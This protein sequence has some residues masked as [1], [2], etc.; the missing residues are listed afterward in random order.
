MSKDTMQIVAPVSALPV[1]HRVKPLPYIAGTFNV[2]TAWSDEVLSGSVGGQVTDKDVIY[3]QITGA[4]INHNVQIST[5]GFPTFYVPL[6]TNLAVDM[7]G[8]VRRVNGTSAV[9]SQVNI[10]NYGTQKS[11]QA[12][13]SQS[14][15]GTTQTFKAFVSGSLAEH[16][17]N[18][19]DSRLSTHN[20]T[21]DKTMFQVYDPA[22]DLFIRNPTCWMN[23]LDLSGLPIWSEGSG[24]NGMKRGGVLVTPRHILCAKHYDY[25]TGVDKTIGFLGSDNVYYERYF[26]EKV[27][28]ANEADWTI[29]GLDSALP[30]AVKVVPV[31]P[32]NWRT[33]LAC[34]PFSPENLNQE[35]TIPVWFTDQWKKMCAFNFIY[36]ENFSAN[37]LLPLVTYGMKES[38]SRY[39]WLNYPQTGTSG[40]PSGLIINNELVALTC[41][42]GANGGPLYSDQPLADAINTQLAGMAGGYQLTL[43]NLSAFPS[44]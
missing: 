19:V 7:N 33:K 34:I 28:S 23:G 17:T 22:S 43:A 41:F 12:L 42:Q 3:D 11:V 37:A 14:T 5:D 39:S 44:Y 38:D 4:T 20:P 2:S 30:A 21:Y 10:R 31:L 32:Q 40:S 27:Q 6:T 9:A 16:C 36:T 13:C 35:I 29:M 24:N 18:A 25:S 26:T 8:T 1:V 15:G